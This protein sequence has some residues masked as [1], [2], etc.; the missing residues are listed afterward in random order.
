MS[1]GARSN[2]KFFMALAFVHIS[3]IHFG[4]EKGGQTVVD[5]DVKDSIVEDCRNAFALLPADTIRGVIA[6]GD[7]AY[8]G[9]EAEYTQAGIWFDKLTAAIGCLRSNVFIVPGNHDIDRAKISENCEEMLKSIASEG[10][11]KLDK[12]L[13]TE[14][15][16]EQLFH[17]FDD[18][19]LFA[20]AY[21]CPIDDDG[22]LAGDHP[23]TIS[24][25]RVL[26]FV[27][28]N[29][30]LICGA[31]DKKGNLLLGMRQR[32][33]Q[34]NIDGEELVVL[35]HHPLDWLL[36]SED[37]SNYL[38]SRA[39]VVVSGHEHMASSKLVT[40][41]DERK[42]LMISA[43]AT[44]PPAREGKR[45]CFNIIKFDWNE[46]EENLTVRIEPREW[47]AK[48]TR[49]S[50]GTAEVGGVAQSYVLDCP[51]YGSIAKSTPAPIVPS[52]SQNL[53]EPAMEKPSITSDDEEYALVVLSFFRDIEE[54]GR[55]KILSDLN[56]IPKSF[57]GT[58]THSIERSFLDKAKQ[59]GKVSE[60]G[61]ALKA[62]I[63]KS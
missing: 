47:D 53:E 22:G 51:N 41:H 40:A 37:V 60:I 59:A 4:Q 2:L 43:G 9:K 30:A 38:R 28:L 35:M 42:V 45:Y 62:L 17:R 1:H 19:R 23:L 24:E 63:Q 16:R 39:R 55:I 48:S 49:F 12:Y 44:V 58:L 56:I 34:R 5:D 32:V 61:D 13:E 27:G 46:C 31:S 50:A 20:Q 8:S 14:A 29:S 21:D 36:D 11:A 15:D 33:V 26:R 54:S 25:G 3:D 57:K 7:I 18:Y 10:D 6:T 52:A